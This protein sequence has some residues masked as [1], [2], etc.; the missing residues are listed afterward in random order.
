MSAS[1][2]GAIT[3]KSRRIRVCWKL[4]RRKE[5]RGS[6][7]NPTP[8][9]SVVADILDNRSVQPTIARHK[10]GLPQTCEYRLVHRRDD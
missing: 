1:A 2:E 5:R 4:S 6:Q 9:E 3:G 7:Q 10:L 8:R